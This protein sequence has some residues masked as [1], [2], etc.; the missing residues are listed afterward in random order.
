[1]V[2]LTFWILRLQIL[3]LLKIPWRICMLLFWQAIDSEGLFPKA[4]GVVVLM[5]VLF[6][7]PLSWC[8]NLCAMQQLIWDMDSSLF[9]TLVCCCSVSKS[10]PTLCNPMD[11]SMPGLH[12][13]HYLQE[14]AQ[15]HVYWIGDAIQPFHPLSPPSL[16][17]LNLSQH[18]GPS[19][20]VSSSHQVAK[21]L[22]LQL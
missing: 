5:L 22:E 21:V 7:K 16:P 19:Q 2:L 12:I 11:Y 20:W 4:D 8:S 1:M 14:F 10:C 17:A 15:T 6:S 3:I 9:C 13:L 18:Q